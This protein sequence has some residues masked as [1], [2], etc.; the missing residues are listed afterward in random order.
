M[1]HSGKLLSVAENFFFFSFYGL[2]LRH[3][4]VPRLRV[5]LELQLLAYNT[6]TATWDVRSM[7]NICD[8]HHSL[9][10]IPACDLHCSLPQRR[11]LNQL[12]KARQRSNPTSSW[13]LCQVLKPLSHNGNS[14]KFSSVKK[15]SHF[16][17]R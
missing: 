12:S 15:M 16:H 11:I 9:R 10:P 8:L 14:L 7:T 3:M 4:E 2:H 5:K 17:H 1:S 6:A 13:I